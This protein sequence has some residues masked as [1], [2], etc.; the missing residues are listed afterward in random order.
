MG[1][2]LGGGASLRGLRGSRRRSAAVLRPRHVPVPLWRPAHG[3]C[4]GVQR[5][6]RRRPLPGDAGPQRA[7]PDRVGLVR[8]ACGERGDKARDRPSGVDQRQCGPAGGFVPPDGDVLRLDPPVADQR[9]RLLRVDA[10]ALR[11]A[12]REGPGVP[13]GVAGQ[14]VPQGSDG[15][16]E[17][18]GDPG[19]LR[20]L[21]HSGGAARS[22]AVVLQDHRLR[23]TVAR[24]RRAVGRLA[25]ACGHDAAELDRP[26][27]RR[28]RHLHDRGDGRGDHDLHDAA[29]HPVGCHILRVRARASGRATARGARR[30]LGA[31]AA[32]RGAGAR[33]VAGEPRG[34]R[35]EGRGPARRA[36]R[37]PCEPRAGAVLR[38]AVRVDGIRHGRDHGG[39]GARSA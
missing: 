19:T 10:V 15:A 21:R 25:G 11:P 38:R 37:Q 17:R 33:R 16:R 9:P 26:F 1:E 20:A 30:N 18:A 34:G 2:G 3:S 14:L 31:G 24:R 28:G 36:R 13:Q 5:W 8:P 6:G 23:A 32:P 39:A 7:A 29:R 27:G 12:V 35:H 22:D 4:R